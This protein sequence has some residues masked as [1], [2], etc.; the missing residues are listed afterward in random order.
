MAGCSATSHRA[1]AH[2]LAYDRPMPPSTA[3][4]DAD[5]RQQAAA[6][7]P[8]AQL[9]LAL[10]LAAQ[11]DTGQAR[12]W[13]QRAAS[14][15]LSRAQVEWGRMLALGIGGE[16]Q[17]ETAATWWLRAEAAGDAAAAY[18]LVLLAAGDILPLDTDAERRLLGA[19]QAGYPPAMRAVALLLGRLDDA[20]AQTRCVQWLD[21]SAQAGDALAALL[22]AERLLRGEGCPR[23]P[24]AAA[25]LLAQL[26]AL[27]HAPLPAVASIPA[28]LL[29]YR[30]AL[31]ASVDEAVGAPITHHQNP[32]VAEHRGLLS[33][34]ECRHLIA[35]SRLHMRRS[36][37][38]DPNNAEGHAQAVRTS[39]GAT[40][41]PVLEDL[42]A[43][44]IQR[45]LAAA[46]GM[47]LRNAEY[48]SVLHYAPGEEYRP[49]RDYLPPAAVKRD[50]PSAGNRA[51][52]L[53]VYL[54]D[55]VAGGETEFLGRGLRIAPVAGSAV[56]FD[57]LSGD[58]RPDP[59]SLHAGLP[60]REGEKW[61]GTLWFRQHRYRSG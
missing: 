44:L 7:Q 26:H 11:G 2:A 56:V 39:R 1:P 18:H 30:G 16:V 40:V 31:L 19:A 38:L 22:L 17:T 32:Y 43:K 25:T 52:T 5:L 53:C 47:P 29:P 4:Q 8:E 46:A 57:N 34:D 28:S 10:D 61:L 48:L 9:R 60:V 15:G 54:N 50:M 42:G 41:D 49:H 6:G 51:R 59:D 21:R 3:A 36:L 33:T 20:A 45:R 12:A 58:G 27:G 23:Q 37:V 13:L 24:Q 35:L 14:L 55:V